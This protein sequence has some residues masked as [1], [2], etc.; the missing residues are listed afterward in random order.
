MATLWSLRNIF[1]F[2]SELIW[3]EFS[4]SVL[5]LQMDTNKPNMGW[6]SFIFTEPW[7]YNSAWRE[8]GHI[9]SQLPGGCLQTQVVGN[10]QDQV[11]I[12][13]HETLRT[14]S[15]LD[16]PHNYPEVSMGCPIGRFP[17]NF[18]GLP[19]WPIDLTRARF[20]DY[21]TFYPQKNTVRTTNFFPPG[22]S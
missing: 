15:M 18:L 10:L 19:I 3:W 6:K 17:I 7:W 21:R 5:R 8:I 13:H 14:A 20:I 22:R 2:F 4:I 12:L 16:I 11:S 9:S 1:F